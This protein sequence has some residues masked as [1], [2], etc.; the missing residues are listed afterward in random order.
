VRSFYD[1]ARLVLQHPL[2]SLDDEDLPVVAASL[3]EVIQEHR[4]TCYACAIMPDHVHLLIRKHRDQAETMI[5]RF[6]EASRKAL[7]EADRRPPDHPVWGGRGWKVFLNSR[8]DMERVVAYIRQNPVKIGRPI[9]E[10]DFVRRYDG[11]LPRQ[12]PGW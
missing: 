2:L 1:Q 8:P 4:Y 9:Q 7:L 10:W 6:Q 11:W 5:Q 3:A 12:L